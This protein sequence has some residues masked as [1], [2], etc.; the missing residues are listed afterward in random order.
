MTRLRVLWSRALDLLVGG[1]RERRL[2]DEIQ[3]HLRLLTDEHIARGMPPAAARA[4]AHRRF[5]GVAQIAETCRDQRGLPRLDALRQDLRFAVR[6]VRRDPGFTATAVVVLALGI[7]V[8][9]MLFTI[10]NA[11][12]LRGLPLRDADRVLFMSTFDDREPDRG[13]AYLDFVD[14]RSGATALSG[15]AAFTS[16][17]VVVAEQERVA[18]RFEGAFVSASAFSLTGVQPILG[19]DF[20]AGDDRPG[21]PAVLILGMDAWRSRYGADPG[22]LGR[23]VTVDGAP[24]TIVGVMPERTGFPATAQVWLPLSHVKGLDL[25]PRSARPL[26]VVARV[27]DGRSIVEARAEIEAIAERLALEHPETNHHV[28]ARVVPVNE[29]FLG[30][31]RNPAWVAFMATGCLVVLISCANAGNLLL[32]RSARRAREM[33]VRL[34]IGASRS[35]LVRQ[36]LIEGAVLAAL[37]GA[38]GLGVALVGVRLFSAAI[39]ERVLP[40]WFDYSPDLRVLMALVGVSAASVLVFALLP[41][42]Q[43]SRPD[44]TLALKDGGRGGTGRSSRW[45]T[46]FLALEFGLTVVLLA[47]FV[48]NVRTAPPALATDRALDTDEVLAAAIT[49]PSEAYRTPAQRHTFFDAL[50]SRL[51]GLPAVSSAAIADVLP[52]SGGEEKRVEV[53][54]QARRADDSP[55]VR[56]VGIT[57]GY[58]ATLGLR[59]VSGRD[60][61]AADGTPG[62]PYVVVN[63]RFVEQLLGQGDVIGRRISMADPKTAGGERTWSTVVGV[64]PSVRQRPAPTPEAVVYVPLRAAP[65]ANAHLLVRSGLKTDALTSLLREEAAALDGSLPLY[66]VRTLA[67]VSR[68]AQWNGRVSNGLFITL[69]FIAVVLATIGLYAVTAHLVVQRTQE[70]GVRMALGAR[71]PQIVRLIARR[72]ALQLSAGLAVG[73]AGSRLWGWAFGSGRDG[74]STTDATTILVVA[75]ILTMLAAAACVFPVRRAARLDPVTAIRRE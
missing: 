72:V 48:V 30:S 64:V 18:E 21:A 27:A 1:R 5:G 67:R 29:Q 57:P 47:H 37:G 68:D 42:L 17:P 60:L 43:A 41:A 74:I 40:Y 26:R 34:S 3:E 32:A 46:A 9:N 55:G 31:P 69:T 66:R 11:H 4:A 14:W 28:R 38:A 63:E 24:A 49:L 62:R 2:Q 53:E 22:V 61:E 16:A 35:R 20:A 75:A 65:P 54:G 12:T 45:T 8:N 10:L 44:V 39:P 58:F 19:R 15:M 73:I 70:I 25:Q 33:A 71:P 7:G 50:R 59:A 13:V 6:L 51:A 52:L 36:L 23:P 56:V